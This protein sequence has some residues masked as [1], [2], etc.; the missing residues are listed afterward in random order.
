MS[1][2]YVFLQSNLL[3]LPIYLWFSARYAK[4]EWRR[5]LG[6]FTGMNAVTHPLVFFVLLSLPLSF[7]Q[8]ILLAEGVAI[9]AETLFLAWLT[10]VSLPLCFATAFFA[11]LV[12]WQLAPAITYAIFS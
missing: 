8:G 9:G 4:G 1:Y 7:L 12:S 3:E 6:L 5:D 10:G 2:L 11:N